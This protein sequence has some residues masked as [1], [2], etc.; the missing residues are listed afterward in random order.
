M[1]PFQPQT[2]DRRRTA[3]ARRLPEKADGIVVKLDRHA[4]RGWDAVMPA[5]P[6]RAPD[7]GDNPGPKPVLKGA[8]ADAVGHTDMAF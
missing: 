1:G 8:L 2:P 5:P 4:R 6:F 3:H 7:A